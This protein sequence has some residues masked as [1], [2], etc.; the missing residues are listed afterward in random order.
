MA[1]DRNPFLFAKGTEPMDCNGKL[2]GRCVNCQ[3]IDRALHSGMVAA[4]QAWR[5]LLGIHSDLLDDQY[6]SPTHQPSDL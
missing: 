3:A 2:L 4:A 5:P 1:R 6:N